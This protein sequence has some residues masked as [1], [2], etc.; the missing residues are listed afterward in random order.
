MP[1]E[2]GKQADS[3]TSVRRKYEQIDQEILSKRVRDNLSSVTHANGYILGLLWRLS[4]DI[5]RGTLASPLLLSATHNTQ[6]IR[7]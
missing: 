5:P 1:A 4:I 6:S 7:R 3:R 2:G